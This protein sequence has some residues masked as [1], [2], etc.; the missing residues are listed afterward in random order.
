M[1]LAFGSSRTA[2]RRPSDGAKPRIT[3]ARAPLSRTTLVVKA[4]LFDFLT[5]KVSELQQY[6]VKNPLRSPLLWGTYD[7]LYCSKPT[8]VGGPLK[9][10]PGP[11][12]A[13]GQSARQVLE[14]PG[15]LVN[16]VKFKTLGFLP[17]YSRQYGQI[18]PV[19][20]D[21]F[22]L[23]ITEGELNLGLGT[24]QKE[25][26][27]TR[28]IQIVYLDDTLRIARFLPSEDL[29]DEESEEAQGGPESDEILFVFQRVVE[30]EEEEEEEVVE[31]VEEEEEERPASP[32]LSLFGGGTRKIE[33]LATQVERSVE[34]QRTRKGTQPFVVGERGRQQEAPAED[35]RFA[36]QQERERER[37]EAQARQVTEQG[38]GGLSDEE[39]AQKEKEERA[40]R[41]AAIREQLAELAEELKEKQAA[42]R[43]AAREV[44]EVQKQNQSTLR[45]V[46]AAEA[47]IAD[48]EEEVQQ[49][50]AALDEASQARQAAEAAVKEALAAVKEAET[51]SKQKVGAR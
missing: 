29:V 3:A 33:G 18:Q 46:A 51:A 35:P 38:G 19:T 22:V 30:A 11:V 8:A 10:G 17:G 32:V 47:A 43:E 44:R 40:Q 14:E 42:A 1:A 28:K 26:D 6:S 25:F 13:P 4:G 39:R 2:V 21:T 36:K 49:V 23:R 20:G 15:T 27:I 16:E 5:P 34:A 37:V 41:A 7:V 48:A 31:E 45:Q 50:S 24:Q 12:L 9:K